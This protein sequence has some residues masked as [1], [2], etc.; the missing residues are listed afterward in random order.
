MKEGRKF[1]RM[2]TRRH[3]AV[4]LLGR[5]KKRRGGNP[6]E[7]CSRKTR[8][9]TTLERR[10]PCCLCGILQDVRRFPHCLRRGT[11]MAL[12]ERKR[13]KRRRRPHWPG[14]RTP[15][16]TTQKTPEGRRGECWASRVYTYGTCRTPLSHASPSLVQEL[17]NNLIHGRGFS[18]PFGGLQFPLLGFMCQAGGRGIKTNRIRHHHLHG[19]P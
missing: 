5:G 6:K 12:A 19:L 11:V 18:T 1:D 14:K 16:K 4:V 2:S 7:Y 8:A 13:N 17:E 15:P 10:T 3:Q 9:R